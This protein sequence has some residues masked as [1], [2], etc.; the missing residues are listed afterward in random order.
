MILLTAVGDGPRPARL[1][2]A[3][4][5]GVAPG[6]VELL[7][8]VTLVGGTVGGYI[9]FSGVHR[10]SSGHRRPGT[11]LVSPGRGSWGSG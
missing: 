2:A 3:L 5:G 6:R 8:L 7:P 11:S 9:T 4:H 10:C 1:R